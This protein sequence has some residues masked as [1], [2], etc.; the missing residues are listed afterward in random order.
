[1]GEA[2]LSMHLSMLIEQFAAALFAA[3]AWLVVCK[4]MPRLRRKT[5]VLYLSAAV[6]AVAACL[7]VSGGVTPTASI[8]AVIVFAILYILYKRALK[9]RSFDAATIISYESRKIS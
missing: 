8:A 5:R 2:H 4:L 7:A 3:V 6:L 9:R 1:M